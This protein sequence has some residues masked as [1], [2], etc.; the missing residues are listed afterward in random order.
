MFERIFLDAYEACGA[1]IVGTFRSLDDPDRWVWIR[2][3]PDA[4][5]RG[6]ALAAF[7]EGEIVDVATPRRAIALIAHVA[8]AMLLRAAPVAPAT[9][10]ADRLRRATSSENTYPRQ[11]VRAEP[12]LT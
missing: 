9:G 2:A 12:R 4:A 8:A 1:S 7:Y 5:S 3:F 6:R 10:A 11:P